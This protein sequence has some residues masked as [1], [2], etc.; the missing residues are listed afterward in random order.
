MGTEFHQRLRAGFRALAAEYPRR[1]RL[2]DAARPEQAIANEIAA[3]AAEAIGAR[4][5]R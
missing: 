1:C 2:I 3:L 5:G 4:A